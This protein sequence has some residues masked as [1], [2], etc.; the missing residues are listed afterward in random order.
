MEPRWLLKRATTLEAAL[1]ELRQ[2]RVSIV[3]CE[4]NLPPGS[5][6]DLLTQASAM[7]DPPLVIVTSELANESL[8]AEALNLGAHDVLAKP[9]NAGEAVRVLGWAWLHWN[10]IS[11]R[12]GSRIRAMKM[13]AV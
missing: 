7:P 11:A 5:W 2:V 4:R 9:L 8:W 10:S 13:A 1:T 6:K 12:G 3:V